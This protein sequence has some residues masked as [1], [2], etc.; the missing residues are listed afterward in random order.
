MTIYVRE[1]HPGENYPAHTTWEQKLQFAKDCREQDGIQNPLLVDDLDG[2][3]HRQYGTLPNMIYIVDRN[4]TVAYKAMWT[5][6]QEITAVLANLAIADRLQS[7]GIRLKPSYTEKINY[8]PAEYAGGLREKV[9]DRA[10]AEAWSDY[11]AVFA[12][13]QK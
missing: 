13:R 11:Q 5:D 10:G 6:H 7:Q 2:T 3:V 4:G 12:A 8:I 1:P 9:F